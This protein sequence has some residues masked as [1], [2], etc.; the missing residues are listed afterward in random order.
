MSASSRRILIVDDNRAIHDDYQKILVRAAADAA[1]SAVEGAL[2]E[3]AAQRSPGRR[4]NFEL[5][6]ALQGEEAIEL[7]RAARTGGTPFSLAFVDI[8]MPPGIDG[9]ETAQRLWAIDPDL[10]VVICSA[11]SDYSWT[12][13]AAQFGAADRWVI[14]KKPFDNIEVLQ[15]AHALVEK[16]ALRQQTKAQVGELEERVA[17]RTADLSAALQRLRE[18]VA[19]RERGETERRN[20][21]RKL[22]ETQR[23]EGL[24]VL[25]GGVAHDFNN[26]LTGVL[27]SA[28]LARLDAPAGSDLQMHLQLIEENSRRAA[29]LCE[30]LLTYAG[31]TRVS[32][33]PLDLNLLV[34]ESLELL[35][36]SVPKD[37]DFA[38]E[39]AET[40]PLIKGDAAR[41]RQVVMNLVLNA[42]EALREPPRRIRLRSGQAALDAAALAATAHPA[43]AKPGNFVFIEVSDTGAGIATDALRRIFEPFYTTK[44]TGRGLGLSAVLGIMRNHRGALDVQSEVGRGT[45]FRAYFPVAVDAVPPPAGAV[46]API[47][48]QGGTV[49]LADDE[50]SVRLA[51]AAT[52]RRHGFSVVAAADGMEAVALAKQAPAPFA[53]A[54]LDVTMPR[55]DGLGALGELRKLQPRLPV[56]LVT[57]FDARGVAEKI[58]QIDG[59]RLLQKPFTLD[60]FIRAAAEHFV[61]AAGTRA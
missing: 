37:A 44:F 55:L 58:A 1:L 13:M 57:G 11:Y 18:E 38:V 17:A 39:L 51:A 42:A 24:G 9:I 41:L 22:E 54:V 59:V 35:H 48:V 49:L 47:R 8:R 34:R 16:W 46:P 28:S 5:S 36:V 23:L 30:Q 6:F 3:D 45:T 32:M 29:G 21:E 14:L 15:L 2:F 26:I 40:P 43:E 12:D 61:A 33:A 53:G 52:L 31:R 56:V 19:E 20:I 4:E 60:E 27:V 50:E 25:A 7:A 10:Q